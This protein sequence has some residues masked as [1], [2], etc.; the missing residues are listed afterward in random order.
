MRNDKLCE[1]QKRATPVISTN[2]FVLVVPHCQ[3]VV[4]SPF[5]IFTMWSSCIIECECTNYNLYLDACFNLLTPPAPIKKRKIAEKF[6]NIP[7]ST[8]LSNDIDLVNVSTS[9]HV[10]SPVPVAADVDLAD[11]A[12][13]LHAPPTMSSSTVVGRPSSRQSVRPR[14]PIAATIV[15]VELPWTFTSLRFDVP[16]QDE[17]TCNCAMCIKHILDPT[18]P[19]ELPSP[20]SVPFPI[21]LPSPVVIPPP[22]VRPSPIALTSP[23]ALQLTV[24]HPSVAV[25]PTVRIQAPFDTPDVS[26]F[27]CTPWGQ[28]GIA[29]C[30]KFVVEMTPT[31]RQLL[32]T[33]QQRYFCCWEQ[34]LNAEKWQSGKK[35]RVADC[36]CVTCQ[37][38]DHHTLLCWGKNGPRK[39]VTVKGGRDDKKT[40]MTS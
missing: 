23:V 33:R 26:C 5:L 15:P 19:P 4:S 27:A 10:K 3:L 21:A 11:F 16:R 39:F 35:C 20:V 14:R 7:S 24:P 34:Q 12:S 36:W 8:F 13:D 32:L 38:S 28:H 18:P 22:V 29:E 1:L 6:F 40:R 17:T 9:L 31:Q 2:S 30:R 25:T 37:K